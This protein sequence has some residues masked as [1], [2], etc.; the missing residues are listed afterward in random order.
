MFGWGVKPI[1]QQ[2]LA[3]IS[4]DFVKRYMTTATAQ[5]FA[6]IAHIIFTV[7][8][9]DWTNGRRDLGQDIGWKAKKELKVLQVTLWPK[10][11][12]VTKK[13]LEKWEK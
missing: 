11:Y 9:L 8:T 2:H 1:G 3:T 13:G 5:A 10:N 12:K 6:N 4:A 7:A